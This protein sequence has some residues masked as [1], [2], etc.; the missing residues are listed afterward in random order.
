MLLHSRY[1]REDVANDF[2]VR[3]SRYWEQGVVR[4]EN[5]YLLFVTLEKKD[6]PPNHRYSDR[7]ISRSEFDWQSQ[8]QESRAG[9]G[10]KYQNRGEQDTRFHLLVRRSLRTEDLRSSPF[11]YLGRVR[12][13]SWE[14]DNPIN[15]RWKLDTPVP[16]ELLDE[17]KVPEI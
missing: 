4:V 1:K 14:G 9:R 3:R 12:F 17:L 2:G 7:F 6:L 15:I 16:L 11:V 13:V 5:D 10:T 8:A